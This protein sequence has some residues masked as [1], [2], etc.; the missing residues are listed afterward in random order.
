MGG[1]LQI[2]EHCIKQKERMMDIL[3]TRHPDT[4]RPSSASI[5]SYTDRPPELVPMDITEN[6]ATEIAGSLSRGS[7]TGGT[8][9]VR[10]QHWILRFRAAIRELQLTV[11]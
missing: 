11:M 9:S 5:E 3:H 10:L 2:E 6:T 8:K 4:R 7:G 1:V